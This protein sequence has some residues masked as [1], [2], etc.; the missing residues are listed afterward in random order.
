[1]TTIFSLLVGA[2]LGTRYKVVCLLPVIFAAAL[3]IAALGRVHRVSLG[4]TAL[5]ALAAGVALQIGYLLGVII[6]ALALTSL[7]GPA[8]AAAYLRARS[9]SI[10]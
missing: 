3:A 2:V 5:T 1:M 4:W 6:R 10:S 7:V 8:T 9:A